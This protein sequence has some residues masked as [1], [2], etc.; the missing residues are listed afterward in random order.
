MSNNNSKLITR[1]N[2]TKKEMNDPTLDAVD[3]VTK[4]KS[5]VD[6]TE[7]INLLQGELGKLRILLENHIDPDALRGFIKTV[8]RGLYHTS[9]SMQSEKYYWYGHY[10]AQ[11]HAVLDNSLQETKEKAL[12]AEI[13]ARSAFAPIMCHLYKNGACQHKVLANALKMNKSNL[14]KEM[15]KM[16]TIGLVNKIKGGKFV[17][18]ELTQKGY[19][20]LNKHYQFSQKLHSHSMSVQENHAANSS[21]QIS[22]ILSRKSIT[23]KK[24][25]DYCFYYL[26]HENS[27]KQ[28]LVVEAKKERND[29]PQN[30]FSET[31]NRYDFEDLD[32]EDS[33]FERRMTYVQ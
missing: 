22:D 9:K 4:C 31:K 3:F 17:Y 27:K 10:V 29:E 25:F 23:R 5:T 20:F 14:S 7:L 18:Y 11:M 19:V 26:S 13:T 1:K 2:L 30:P 6:N 16:V 8:H 15:D 32:F 12:L 28:L 24:Q 33:H 21:Y